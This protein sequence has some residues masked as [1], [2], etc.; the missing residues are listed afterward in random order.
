MQTCSPRFGRPGTGRAAAGLH[1]G[2]R[3]SVLAPQYG[4]R[5]PVRRSTPQVGWYTFPTIHTEK[6]PFTEP[7]RRTVRQT[8]GLS[9]YAHLAQRAT[10][11]S[12]GG[13]KSILRVRRP[14]PD[15]KPRPAR[16][17]G[18]RAG[19]STRQPLRNGHGTF[20]LSELSGALWWFF[21]TREAATRRATPW[22][23]CGRYG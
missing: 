11:R 9:S 1:F 17:V 6:A 14:Q 8:H 4:N 12:L 3:A 15:A 21:R 18:K 5:A 7:E 16:Q 2:L 13:D 20:V 10:Q 22:W 23:G 19:R